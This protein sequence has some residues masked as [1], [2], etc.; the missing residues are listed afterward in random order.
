[1][2]KNKIPKIGEIVFVELLNFNSNNVKLVD[3]DL[4]GLILCTEITKYK[5]DLKGVVK[6]DEIFPVVVLEI[7]DEGQNIDLSYVKVKYDKRELLKNC[8]TYQSKF[9]KFIKSSNLD[10]DEFINTNINS[11]NY[12]DSIYNNINISK[13]KFDKFL[14]NPES[15]TNSIELINYVKKNIIIKPY[16]IIQEFKL[17]VYD[18]SSLIL[19]KEILFKIKEILNNDIECESKCEL[20]CRSSPFY[21]IKIK[22]NNLNFITDKIEFYKLQIKNITNCYNCVLEFDKDYKIIKNFEIDII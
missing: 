12:L 1:M 16:E 5:A 22:N 6:L 8:Y 19:L 2:Y 10:L 11:D 20:L 15:F 17:T 21:Q 13:D 18:N 7:D 14:L 4:N 9:Y 3:Y